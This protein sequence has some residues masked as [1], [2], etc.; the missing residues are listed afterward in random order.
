VKKKARKLNRRWIGCEQLERRDVLTSVAFDLFPVSVPK[1][2]GVGDVAV[3]DMDND[4]DQDVVSVATRGG[5]LLFHENANGEGAFFA[6]RKIAENVDRPT[7][8]LVADFD[9]DGDLDV[10]LAARGK[11]C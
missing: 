8:A 3:G 9:L 6:S 7:S 5:Q 2:D 11:R 10:V 4:G 1:P